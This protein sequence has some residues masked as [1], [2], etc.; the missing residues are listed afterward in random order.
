M[1]VPFLEVLLLGLLAS[2]NPCQIAISLA[3]LAGIARA[4]G[5]RGLWLYA[6][7]RVVAHALLAWVILLIIGGSEQSATAFRGWF[8][9]V[10]WIV[11]WLLVAV[12]VFF[13]WRGLY[14]CR[15]HD[16]CH[17]SGRIIRQ[18]GPRG[19]FLLGMALAMAFCPESAVFYFG[20]MLPLSIAHG[21]LLAFPLAYAIA[22]ALPVLL[23]G[24]LYERTRS[25]ATRISR[26]LFH[27]QRLVNLLFALLLGALAAAIWLE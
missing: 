2:V 21:Q 4:G 25:I 5:M 3:A 1:G 22:A 13:L 19:A 6:A 14:P 16:S 23:I 17:D 18:V 8:S 9:A 11:P 24:L 27:A 26:T 7:G 12:A 15:H 10:E 20:M